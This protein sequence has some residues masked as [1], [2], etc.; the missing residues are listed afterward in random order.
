MNTDGDYTVAQGHP[1][2]AGFQQI[3]MFGDARHRDARRL[4]EPHY[5]PGVEVCLCRSGI[6]RWD[7][8]GEVVEIRPG[9]LSVTRPSERHGGLDSIIGPGRLSWVIVPFQEEPP[10]WGGE[11]AAFL[12][13]D[14][15]WVAS[16][17]ARV[18]RRH[19]GGIPAAAAAFDQLRAELPTRTQ[20]RHAAVRVALAA[21]LLAI[22]RAIA[23]KAD[24]P[25]ERVPVP[26]AVLD[27]LREVSADCLHSWTSRE[28][29]VRAGMGLTAFTDW[30]KRATGRSPRW[31]LLEVRLRRARTQLTDTDK[32]I[33]E[34]AVGA[35]FSSSQHFAGAFRTLYGVTPSAFRTDS[36]R[37]RSQT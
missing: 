32:T 1:D 30:C 4:L 37:P 16:V 21:L 20:G 9:E 35:G 7:V 26:A 28:M 5:N 25:A 22:A 29:A 8:E 2:L 6:Y 10:G 17:V 34:V 24:D 27:V 31:Y 33:T 13:D 12:G 11:V 15:P 19:L 14:A 18:R 3:V 23:E 36:R